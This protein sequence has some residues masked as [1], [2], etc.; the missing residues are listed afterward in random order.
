MQT[1][2][3][4]GTPIGRGEPSGGSG[5]TS[6]GALALAERLLTHG[7]TV[8]KQVYQVGYIEKTVVGGVPL[9]VDFALE[10][11]LEGNALVGLAAKM[12]F[13]AIVQLTGIDDLSIGPSGANDL[14][15]PAGDLHGHATLLDVLESSA[16]LTVDGIAFDA[17]HKIARLTSASGCKV[18]MI[19]GV[20]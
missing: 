12:V 9:D 2:S 16:V 8:G 19:V 18:A 4:P 14:D 10:K 17:T 5:G 11:D 20:V 7:S 1:L 15:L 3:L 6:I 13:F